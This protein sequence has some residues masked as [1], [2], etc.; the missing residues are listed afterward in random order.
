MSHSKFSKFSVGKPTTD[1]VCKLCKETRKPGF[2]VGRIIFGRRHW[3]DI[4]QICYTKE[5]IIPRT[6]SGRRVWV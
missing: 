1:F 6:S 3:Y 5:M 2:R 4:C